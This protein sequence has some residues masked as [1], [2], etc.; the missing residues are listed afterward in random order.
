MGSHLKLCVIHL[1]RIKMGGSIKSGKN[2]ISKRSVR[3]IFVRKITAK[4]PSLFYSTIL[5][6][7]SIEI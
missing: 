2:A 5:I 3:R 6:S 4:T 7:K 1:K